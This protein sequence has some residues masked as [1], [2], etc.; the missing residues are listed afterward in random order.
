MLIDWFTV[1]A[2]A[3][4][5]LILVWLL[6]R[7]LYKPILDA[8]D[9][10]EKRIAAE[11]ADADAK[12]AEA[13][14]QRD[15]F[16]QKNQ[17][18]DKQRQDMLTKAT[19]EANAERQRLM[20]DARKAADEL[21]VKREDSLQR[22][23]AALNAEV[24]RRTQEEVFAI[25]RKTLTDLASTS[26]EAEMTGVFIKQLQ[27]LDDAAKKDFAGTTQTQRSSMIVRSA[28]DLPPAQQAVMQDAINKAFSMAA[29]LSFETVPDVISGIELTCSGRKISWSIADYLA[30][31]EQRI[32][33]LLQGKTQPAESTLQ[34]TS[35]V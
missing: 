31:M 15:D 27:R 13:K 14:L 33:E 21:R 8:I 28:F 18:F 19:N 2:Q 30:S 16:E 35:V 23:H 32:G 6:K 29:S 17:T 26:L 20:E 10:R 11:L 9:A 4:N 3:V 12:R 5:F 24:T 34:E 7:F 1:A 22:E 25:T